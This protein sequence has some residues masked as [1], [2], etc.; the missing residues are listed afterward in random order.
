MTTEWLNDSHCVAFRQGAALINEALI[1][2]DASKHPTFSL[3]SAAVLPNQC[4]RPAVELD[5]FGL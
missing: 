4:P 2:G 5:R 1:I 3:L